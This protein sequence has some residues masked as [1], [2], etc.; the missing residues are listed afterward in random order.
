MISYEYTLSIGIMGALGTT[1]DGAECCYA[2][3]LGSLRA[4]SSERQVLL[5]SEGPQVCISAKRQCPVC[6]KIQVHSLQD[7]FPKYKN[8]KANTPTTSRI[9]R[10]YS[11]T[12]APK[13]TRL[14]DKQM[15]SGPTPLQGQR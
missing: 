6:D 7:S 2:A 14:Y 9:M 11:I 12:M 1:C 5:Q 8:D 10:R 13:A 4:T 3:F 15:F